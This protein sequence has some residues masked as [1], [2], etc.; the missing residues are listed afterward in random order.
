MKSTLHIALLAV[1]LSVVAGCSGGENLNTDKDKA[2]QESL[3]KAAA[4]NKGATPKGKN[5]F[6]RTLPPPKI[7][8]AQGATPPGSSA[9]S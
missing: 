1:C 4:A 2:F 7:V 3:A 6:N 8:P 5:N 9:P